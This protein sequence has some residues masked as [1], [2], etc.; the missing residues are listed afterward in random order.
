LEPSAILTYKLV[1]PDSTTTQHPPKFKPEDAICRVKLAPLD[2][3]HRTPKHECF[4]GY[5]LTGVDLREP[6]FILH[7]ENLAVSFQYAVNVRSAAFSAR[8]PEGPYSV[9][10]FVE[11]AKRV[12]IPSN[13]Q[14]AVI[15]ATYAAAMAELGHGSIAP[16]V[17]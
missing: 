10:L 7:N 17:G 9:F 12:R 1:N 3:Y 11:L 14:I 5:S 8:I 15:A 16:R 4:K 13:F 6:L 2:K